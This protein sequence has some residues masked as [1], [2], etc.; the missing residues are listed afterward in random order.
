[1]GAIRQRGQSPRIMAAKLE[2]V[3]PGAAISCR[4]FARV[5]MMRFGGSRW[6][7]LLQ[8]CKRLAEPENLV[9]LRSCERQE[10]DTIAVA[11]PVTDGDAEAERLA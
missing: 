1:M 7:T 6:P 2:D 9:F 4:R 3:L 11:G 10:L 8:K 5:E